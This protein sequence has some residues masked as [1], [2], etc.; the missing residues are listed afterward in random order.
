MFASGR[1]ILSKDSKA[2]TIATFRVLEFDAR[3][4]HPADRVRAT[5][6]VYGEATVFPTP[7]DVPFPAQ[8]SLYGAS[9]LAGEGLIAAYAEGFGFQG[10]VFRFVSILGPRYTH[11]HVFDFYK[12]LRATPSRLRVLGNGRQRKSYL[13]VEDRVSAMLMAIEKVDGKYSVF[14]LGTDHY[15]EVN[16]LSAGSCQSSVSRSSGNILAV[17]AAGS[18]ITRSFSW[19]ARGSGPSVGSLASTSRRAF[20]R[21]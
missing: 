16:D 5:G 19:I 9:K 20:A 6:L 2:E 8:T 15:C 14:N 4:F 10:L 3:Q 18:A 17:S 12:Q 7:E 1:I 11:G 13:H 21:H